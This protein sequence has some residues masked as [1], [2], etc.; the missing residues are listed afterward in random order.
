L[1]PRLGENFLHH[2]FRIAG[3]SQ[4]PV[5]KRVN[6][7]TVRIIELRQSTAVASRDALHPESI[8]VCGLVSDAH[9]PAV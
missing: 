7:R 1:P 9:P 8:Y 5:R 4:N 2:L 3:M 6:R